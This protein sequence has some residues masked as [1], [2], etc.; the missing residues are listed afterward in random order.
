MEEPSTS[1]RKIALKIDVSIQKVFRAPEPSNMQLV[2]FF[3]A[4]LSILEDIFDNQTF[5]W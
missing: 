1:V 5:F 3:Y 4:K 2:S